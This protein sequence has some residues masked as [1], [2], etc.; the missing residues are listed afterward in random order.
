MPDEGWA[1][2]AG[3]AASGVRVVVR[4]GTLPEAAAEAISGAVAAA[5]AAAAS[6]TR[7]SFDD[8]LP[9]PPLEIVRTF[10]L[11]VDTVSIRASVWSV[12][13]AAPQPS[14]PTMTDS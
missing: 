7:S 8:A 5:S 4:S 6:R 3:R 13:A 11:T 10:A 14:R 1:A 2:G 12:N 9:P